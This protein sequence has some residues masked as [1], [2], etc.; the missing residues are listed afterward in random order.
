MT[1]AE[2]K[3]QMAAAGVVDEDV[4]GYIEIDPLPTEGAELLIE[5]QPRVVESTVVNVVDKFD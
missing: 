1:Y 5:R 3:K 4:I 2:F